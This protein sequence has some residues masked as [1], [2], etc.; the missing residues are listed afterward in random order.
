[1]NH[2]KTAGQ[3]LDAALARMGAAGLH[4]QEVECDCVI[5][6]LFCE[7]DLCNANCAP[8]F[9]SHGMRQYLFGP[10]AYSGHVL[11]RTRE[12]ANAARQKT[13]EQLE[14]EC[15]SEK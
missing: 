9:A 5:G 1:M 11:Y 4:H 10:R 12:E 7:S 15:R 2:E 6:A 3:I 14:A 8:A 13:R